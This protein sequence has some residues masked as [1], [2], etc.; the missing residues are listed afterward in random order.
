VLRVHDP[1]AATNAEFPLGAGA[2]R[3]AGDSD[4]GPIELIVPAVVVDRIEK[5]LRSWRRLTEGLDIAT[6]RHSIQNYGDRKD[7][8]EIQCFRCQLARELQGRGETTPEEE[9][10]DAA[11]A[12]TM[13]KAGAEVFFHRQTKEHTNRFR[14]IAVFKP[15][16]ESTQ[17]SFRVEQ[18]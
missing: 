1:I 10:K 4:S 14:T 7:S 13:K 3:V 11:G 8:M 9:A 16:K 12:E 17:L 18:S 2:R 15:A 5:N 6:V